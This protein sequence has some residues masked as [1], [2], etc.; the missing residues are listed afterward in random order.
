MSITIPVHLFPWDKEERHT[1]IFC[2]RTM[3][4]HSNVLVE[5][6]LKLMHVDNGYHAASV[7]L[8]TSVCVMGCV[9]CVWFKQPHL[10]RVRLMDSRAG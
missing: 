7:Q 4:L 5:K 6:L 2:Q 8:L 3:P 9:E 1:S 10:V